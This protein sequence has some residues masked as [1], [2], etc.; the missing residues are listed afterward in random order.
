MIS[1][2][3]HLTIDV[4]NTK[5]GV[6]TSSSPIVRLS[7][8]LSLSQEPSVRCTIIPCIWTRFVLVAGSC[9]QWGKKCTRTLVRHEMVVVFL[10]QQYEQQKPFMFLETVFEHKAVQQA[11]LHQSYPLWYPMNRSIDHSIYSLHYPK[12]PTMMHA[13]KQATSIV[14]KTPTPQI[15]LVLLTALFVRTFQVEPFFLLVNHSQHRIDI[16]NDL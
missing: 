8:S 15:R 12:T 9:L 11:P 16:N 1:T 13:T 14:L 3:Q 2:Q 4:V 6:L 10:I 7:L 5:W